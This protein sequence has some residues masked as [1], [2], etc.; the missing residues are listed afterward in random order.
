M[1]KLIAYGAFAFALRFMTSTGVTPNSSTKHLV[2]Q[3]GL[4][5]P[6]LKAISEIVA[7]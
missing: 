1:G 2:K 7:A 6:T 4:P 5:N 3:A